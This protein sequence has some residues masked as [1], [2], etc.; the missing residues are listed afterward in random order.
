MINATGN[1]KNSGAVGFNSLVSKINDKKRKW[2]VL[3][4]EASGDEDIKLGE[5]E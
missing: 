5:L 3:E 4:D 1:D 2:A